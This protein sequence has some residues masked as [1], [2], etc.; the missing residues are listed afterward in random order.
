[1]INENP[2]RFYVY[3]Y[4]DPRKP[5]KYK[6]GKYEFDYEPFYVGKGTSYRLNNHIY[7]ALSNKNIWKNERKCKRI[8]EIISNKSYPIIRKIIVNLSEYNALKLE[9]KYCSVIKIIED[10][11]PL[12]NLHNG[13]IGPCGET[14]EKLSKLV[15]DFWK[16]KEGI[17]KKKRA[18]NR[19]KTWHKEHNINGENN[20]NFGNKW[21][22]KQRE[23]LS[24]FLKRTKRHRGQNNPKFK[25]IYK[26]KFKNKNLIIFSLKCFCEENKLNYGSIRSVTRN[27]NNKGWYKNILFIERIEYEKYSKK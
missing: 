7:E 24:S 9:N 3:I 4:F 18:S 16:T 5:G 17:A 1:M 21:N 22:K 23:H 12:L 25:Y 11:G 15:T 2:N 20:P 10:G 26:I 19:F 27:K 13:L 14:K 6:Y 8:L